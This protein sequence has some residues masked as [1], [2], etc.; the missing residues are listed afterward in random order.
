MP[1]QART[2]Q[3]QDRNQRGDRRLQERVEI[4]AVRWKRA[5]PRGG[6][7]LDA[8]DIISG[9]STAGADPG[10]DIGCPA[11]IGWQ[12]MTGT[13]QDADG[14]GRPHLLPEKPHRNVDRNGRVLSSPARVHRNL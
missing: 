13:G 4:P 3:A 6:G 9:P 2:G 12:L 11:G 7:R 1:E 5:Q 8:A 10:G 14:D